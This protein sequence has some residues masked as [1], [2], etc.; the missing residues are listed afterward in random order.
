MFMLP[1][2]NVDI[3]LHISTCCTSLYNSE[4]HG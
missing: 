1:L 3:Y 4:V 2:F